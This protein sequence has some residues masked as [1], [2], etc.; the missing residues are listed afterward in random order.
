MAEF[1]FSLRIKTECHILKLKKR[2]VHYI[3]LKLF[4]E[5]LPNNLK[6]VAP[7]TNKSNQV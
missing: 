6:H 1:Q 4:K 2:N 3:C 7:S 5:F